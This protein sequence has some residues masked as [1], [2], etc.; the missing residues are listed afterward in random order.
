M[1]KRSLNN[2]TY[3]VPVLPDNGVKVLF[4]DRSEEKTKNKKKHNRRKGYDI[5]NP[6]VDRRSEFNIL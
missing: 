2:R 6:A 3:I 4:I 5:H 1:I